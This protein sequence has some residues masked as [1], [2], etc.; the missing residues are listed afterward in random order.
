[1]PLWVATI[2]DSE[3][4][5]TPLGWPSVFM[6]CPVKVLAKGS[7]VRRVSSQPT[8]KIRLFGVVVIPE[9]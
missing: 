1:M 2:A 6:D 5:A 7:I 9:T 4:D 3:D 8:L